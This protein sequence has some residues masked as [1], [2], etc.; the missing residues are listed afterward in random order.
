[1]DL[2]TVAPE[3]LAAGRIPGYDAFYIP[4]FVSVA[5]EEYL[6]QKILSSPQSRWKTLPNRRLQI[7]GGEITSKGSLITQPLPSFFT[8]YPDVLSRIKATRV[9]ENSPHKGPNHVIMNEYLPGQGI[10]PHEDGP[11]YH[12]VVATLS[13]SS[14][15]V[16]HY[17][18]YV[19]ENNDISKAGGKSIDKAPILSLLLEPRSLV[20]SLGTMYTSYL[21]GIDPVEE[22]FVSTDGTSKIANID[23]LRQETRESIQ[24]GH[25]L[26]RGSRYSLTCRDVERVSRL[27]TTF[28]H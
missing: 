4:N 2:E 26:K 1:M 7:W 16:F 18:Q 3:D 24:A 5:E 25:P 20:I 12:P 6:I 10:M 28:S 9:F 11:Q 8:V 27:N 15:A 14:H 22:D 23:S 21:H 19:D 17:Y 13:L